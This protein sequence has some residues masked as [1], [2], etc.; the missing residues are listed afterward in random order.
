MRN[1]TLWVA[2][3]PNIVS[4][5]TI[6]SAFSQS[7]CPGCVVGL[8]AN[9][10]ED[11]IFQTDAT[12]GVARD[13]YDAD[14]SFRLPK[15][16]TPVAAVDPSVPAGIVLDKI[17]I[18]SI[19]NL[20]PGLN[21][22]LNQSEFNVRQNTD[23]C[24]K[25]CGI[26]LQSG[27]FEV[28]VVIE[29]KI[30]FISQTTFF[31]FPIEILPAESVTEGFAT[32]NASGCGMVDVSFRNNVPSGENPGFSYRWDF[33]NGNMS[34]E[35]NPG[36]QRY[37]T[38][39]SY[40]V[41]YQA[42]V[43]TTGFFLTKA[44]VN[45]VRCSDLLGKPD[46]LM[47]VFDPAGEEIYSSQIFD[48]TNPP[49]TFELYL[50]IDTGNYLLKIL[51]ADQGIEGSDANCGTVNF[52]IESE[53][54]LT[55]ENFEVEIVLAHPIDTISSSDTITVF[56][57]PVP[58]PVVFEGNGKYC[59]GDSVILTSNASYHKQWYQNELPILN[60]FDSIAATSTG[61]YTV[62]FTDE[63]GCQSRS[64]AVFLE[65][66]EKPV[67]P[68]FVVDK[69]LLKVFDESALPTSYS[70]R[71]YLDDE[72]IPDQEATSLCSTQSG[73]YSLEVINEET[74]CSSIY[75]TMVNFQPEFENCGLTDAAHLELNVNAIEVFPNP[76][77]GIFHAR[78]EL[79][80]PLS[81][82]IRIFDAFG[83]LISQ[84]K[85]HE[86]VVEH[87]HEFD[88]TNYP[89]GMY[90]LYFV[91]EDFETVFKLIKQ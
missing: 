36:I 70:L 4:I 89:D 61:S 67:S 42:I 20:P 18:K 40:L 21:W 17:V 86:F 33:G 84:N 39:G 55:D 77:D 83:R 71:W 64:E 63:N 10:P 68:V 87:R 51:D 80:K 31:T 1:F 23:G 66:F 53:G 44:R 59:K 88:L 65:F 22:E 2:L 58:T 16:T 41:H 12:I 28:E 45:K 38:P 24:M 6:T 47:K 81:Y 82:E 29:A 52:N 56:S 14:I 34:L 25:I 62:L 32:S 7:G 35:E 26:P 78:V 15:S 43:D 72:I 91:F 48:N 57:E 11:T 75:S 8:P 46:L 60:N 54:V 13:Y 37:T 30:L 9:L 79:K 90:L 49:L 73:V 76:G 5:L 74:G 50:P 3:F 69:N 85:L 27:Y 19:S